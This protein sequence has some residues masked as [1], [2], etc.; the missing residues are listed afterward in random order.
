MRGKGYDRGDGTF[1]DLIITYNVKLPDH[2]SDHQKELLEQM[3]RRDKPVYRK[4]ITSCLPANTARKP[5]ANEAKTYKAEVVKPSPPF[6][7]P[8]FSFMNVEKVVNPPQN[9]VVRRR[10][11]AG[12]I[13]P[14]SLGNE[15]KI[16]IRKQP[17][18]FTT[19]VPK[20][21]EPAMASCTYFD[22]TMRRLP[23]TK[24]PTPTKRISLNIVL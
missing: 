3:R 7:I 22:I 1:G 18:T 11:T 15:A 21:N 17:N 16:P 9:P 10:R 2:L 13:P 12:L 24:L 4:L 5:N 6:I 8:T 14:L 19:I 23:P 20:G